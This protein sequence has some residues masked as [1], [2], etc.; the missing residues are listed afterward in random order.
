MAQPD[1]DSEQ[2]TDP[3]DSEASAGVAAEPRPGGGSNG[4]TAE[5]P[6][7][8]VRAPQRRLPAYGVPRALVDGGRGPAGRRTFVGP[9]EAVFR[10]PFLTALPV[11]LL[12][13]AAMLL[14]VERR[15]N[16]TASSKLAVSLVD[17]NSEF[18]QQQVLGNQLLAIDFAR[19]IATPQVIRET[20]RVARVTSREVETHLSAS[21]IPGSTIIR[22]EAKTHSRGK[23]IALANAG[24]TALGNYIGTVS[25]D[26]DAAR[27]LNAYRRAQLRLAQA[28]ARV[29]RLQDS[30][31]SPATVRRATADSQA[32]ALEASNLDNLYRIAQANAPQRNRARLLTVA[33]RAS[34]DFGSVLERLILIGAVAGAVVGVTLALARA[35]QPSSRRA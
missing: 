4:E 5:A 26:T 12:I 22:V 27:R 18:L 15:A 25:R 3:P 33:A 29:T 1:A 11:V 21:P 7:E 17:V 2:P 34:S 23:S 13:A 20:S 30:G 32:A 31:A 19:A 6:W 14:G 35:N 16:Y 8:V 10:H 9:L 28:Q 24:S